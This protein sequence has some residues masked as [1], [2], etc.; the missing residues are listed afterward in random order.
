MVT[1]KYLT[2]NSDFKTCHFQK[3]QGYGIIEHG[4]VG[5]RTNCSNFKFYL[6]EDSSAKF[7]TNDT[8]EESKIWNAMCLSVNA[9][10][11]T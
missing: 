3:Q 10:Y 8:K 7:T 4:R 6:N 11:T 2:C 1:L 5:K 9:H